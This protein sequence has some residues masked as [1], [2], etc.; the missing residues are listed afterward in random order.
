MP[1]TDLQVQK[2][3][4]AKAEFITFSKGRTLTP[5]LE[6]FGA[7]PKIAQ[8]SVAQLSSQMPGVVFNVHEGATFDWET[9]PN[10]RQQA[11]AVLMDRP[12]SQ[13]SGIHVDET[14]F[15]PFHA[16]VHKFAD[17]SDVVIGSQFIYKMLAKGL[18]EETPAGDASKYKITGDAF[19]LFD[20]QGM[21]MRYLRITSG[22]AQLPIPL[23]SAFTITQEAGTTGFK[24]ADVVSIRLAYSANAH[25]AGDPAPLTTEPLGLATPIFGVQIAVLA[26]LVSVEHTAVFPTGVMSVAVYAGRKQG[27]ETF[28]GW[29]TAATEGGEYDILG[30]PD[31]NGIRPVVDD[32]SGVFAASGDFGLTSVTEGGVTYANAV[33]LTAAGFM[34]PQALDIIGTPQVAVLKNG[35]LVPD[36][37]DVSTPWFF[38]PS[39]KTF[40]VNAALNPTDVYELILP[41]P[42][43]P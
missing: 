10:N 32:N 22:T 29:I 14:R 35:I 36:I 37:L 1:T 9:M 38:S 27:E 17:S 2:G 6:K 8:K 12:P 3:V 33:D 42:I 23:L 4:R 19:R 7:T 21:D 39:R 5:L 41:T 25:S 26:N 15:R 20:L 28:A 43:Q 34:V 40:A 18:P 31:T 24:V 13:T 30:F 11:L 16:I